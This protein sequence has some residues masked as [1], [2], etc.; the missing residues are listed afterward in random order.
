[1]AFLEQFS[2][3]EKSLL[4]SLPYRAGVWIGAMDR[5]GGVESKNAELAVLEKIIDQKAQGMFESAFVHEV[6]VEICTHKSDWPQWAGK[7]QSVPA[8]CD[9]AVAAIAEK[10]SAH[11]LDAYRKNVMYIAV[12]VAKAFREFDA[13]TPLLSQMVE[14]LRCFLDKIAGVAQGGAHESANLRNI[15]YEED[16][17][18]AGLSRALGIDSGEENILE[19]HEDEGK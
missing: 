18:L 15:S 17:A 7:G 9:K 12:E 19:E 1:M 8:D 4:V 6:M 13:H 2:A 3:E 10:L 11:D 5:S 16:V 14:M